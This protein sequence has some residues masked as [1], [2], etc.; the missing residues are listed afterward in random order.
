MT[1]KAEYSV[2][3]ELQEAVGELMELKESYPQIRL[4][5]NLSPTT[6]S[7][8]SIWSWASC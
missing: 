2:K 3:G 4:I 6:M 8:Q 1:D 7:S 5:Q